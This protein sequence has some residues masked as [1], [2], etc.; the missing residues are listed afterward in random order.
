MS[1]WD[2]YARAAATSHRSVTSLLREA[3][4]LRV[5]HL[6]LGY[7][8]YIDFR[9]FEGDLRWSDKQA[10]GGMRAQAI[11][12][13]LLID[14]YSS[15]LSLDKVTMYAL[16]AGFDLPIPRVRATYRSLRPSSLPS[17]QTPEDLAQYLT[18][19]ASDSVY[20]KR[21]FGA[22]GRGNLLI[23]R[24]DGERVV[25]GS[26]RTEPLAQFCAA[27]DD[28]RTLGWILQEPLSPHRDIAALTGSDK[29]SGLRLHTFLSAQSTRVIKAIFKVNVGARDSD[30]FEHGASGNMLGAV[31]IA[32]GKVVRA[33][34]GVGLEQ[35]VSP[36]HPLTG[37]PIVG[38]T[39]PNWTDVVDLVRD[40]QKAFPGFICPGWDIALCADGPKILEVNAFG[41]IDLSQHAYRRGFLDSELLALLRERGLDALLARPAHRRSRS[42]QNNRLGTRKHHWRW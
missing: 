2:S 37:A 27:L 4:R 6:R 31:D 23:E 39:L 12:E 17:L 40:A 7:S 13:E 38:F 1:L 18:Q 25:L 9:L 24:V 5:S 32:T 21:A 11:L 10:F 26:G 3:T 35:R 30:N 15:L 14:D 28:G 41:D 20:L 22:Y 16:L 36:K 19:N 33:V 42:A 29:I 8:E 34:A